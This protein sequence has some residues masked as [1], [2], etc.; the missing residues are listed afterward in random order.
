M[1]E[2]ASKKYD[3]FYLSDRSLSLDDKTLSED[4]FSQECSEDEDYNDNEDEYGYDDVDEEEYEYDD[5]E[6]L[7]EIGDIK[8]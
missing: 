7:S 8:I 6:G 1:S 5:D 2:K 3:E 4:S